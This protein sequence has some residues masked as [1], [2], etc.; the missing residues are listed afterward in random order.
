LPASACKRNLNAG[1]TM[2]C[3]VSAPLLSQQWLRSGIRVRTYPD[4][5]DTTTRQT[6]R[7]KSEMGDNKRKSN[8]RA[9]IA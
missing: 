9:F 4:E 2:P 5:A 3:S 6:P 1:T 7:G 8:T